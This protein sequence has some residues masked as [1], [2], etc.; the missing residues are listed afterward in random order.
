MLFIYT[1]TPR[2]IDDAAATLERVRGAGLKMSF[3]LFSPTNAY[4]DR[5]AGLDRTP[6]EFFSRS[7]AADNLGWTAESLAHARRT[8]DA[9]LE[10]APEALV[11]S[12]A[13]NDWITDPAP[14]FELDAT[15]VA[16]GCLSRIGGSLSLFGTDLAPIPGA[17]CCTSD[18][19]CAT[20]RLYSGGLASRLRLRVP[21]LASREAFAR[22]LEI[23]DHLFG[24]Y[25]YR[26]D[27]LERGRDD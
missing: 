4:R 14:R 15:G 20:C 5:L 22:W 9:L 21:D 23:C 12:R 25:I 10:R 2:N 13:Y 17:K 7:S 1:L 6:S 16:T 18:I 11:Y 26:S 27:W 19:D 24:I 3:N 8:V